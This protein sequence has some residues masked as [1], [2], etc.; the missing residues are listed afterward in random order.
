M[1]TTRRPIRRR[2]GRP[3]RGALPAVVLAAALVGG[4]AGCG[5][6]APPAPG[7]AAA[8]TGAG[9]TSAPAPSTAGRSNPAAAPA[10]IVPERTDVAYVDDGTT[11]HRLDLFV[12]A[13][14]GP[15][16]FPVV[17]WVHGGGWKGGDKSDIGLED[18]QMSQTKKLLLDRGY[19]VAAP[20]YRLIPNTRF[21]EPM[22][23][24]AAAVRH[25]RAHAGEYGLDAGRF[26][27]MGDSAGAHLAAM[28]ALTPGR[29]DLQGTLGTTG[30]DASVK[31]FVGFYGL[32]DLRTRTEDQKN[33]CGGGKPGAESSHGR[34]IGADPDSPEGEKV[35]ATASPVT[36][37]GPATPPVLLFS[38]KEDCTAPYPQA[39]GFKAALD[40]AG[41]ANELTLI[42]K[43]HADP[44]FFADPALQEQLVRFLDA[45]VK[46]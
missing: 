44:Q 41:V 25:L 24:V 2:T 10:Q 29:A 34:L 6:D 26:A 18:I 27:L 33:V 14:R 30:V 45:H 38:G 8:S 11:E 43:P 5:T 19:A 4:L 13:D 12:P 36:Y 37:V 42:D 35:A 15:G 23:D 9:T 40:R 39:E 21:P 32:Y 20:N 3:A 17:V 1:I 31:A 46:R 7:P 16:P 28:T 22:Q